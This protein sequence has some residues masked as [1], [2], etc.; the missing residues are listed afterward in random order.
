MTGRNRKQLACTLTCLLVVSILCSLLIS[1]L[2]AGEE[3][4]SPGPLGWGEEGIKEVG[5]EWI[6]DFPGTADDRSHWD[7][8]CDGLWNKLRDAGWTGRFRWTDWNAWEQEWKDEPRAGGG[9]GD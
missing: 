2:G 1:V 6:N 7:E 3:P 8:S 9:T 5:V 4:S